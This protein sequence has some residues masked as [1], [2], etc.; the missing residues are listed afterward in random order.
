MANDLNKV[1]LIGRLTRDPEYKNING[2]PLVNFSIA[3]NRSYSVAGNRKE[4]THYFDC[5]AWGKLADIIRQY[6]TKGKQVLV[7][8]RLKL[9]SWDS[10]EGKKMSRIKIFTENL[11]LLGGSAGAGS[12]QSNAGSGGDS[13]YG[14]GSSDSSTDYD[15]YDQSATEDDMPF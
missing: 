4:E 3:N 12:N 7:E 1:I 6:A 10:P 2:T 13:G 9:D 8:G 5:E 11:Q 15:S 14:S